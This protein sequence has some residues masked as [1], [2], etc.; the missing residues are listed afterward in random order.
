[1]IFTR[2][3]SFKRPLVLINAN[4]RISFSTLSLPESQTFVG[5]SELRK[6]V[7]ISVFIADPLIV[8]LEHMKEN[9]DFRNCVHY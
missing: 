6:L 5:F 7:V 4:V 2:T 8:L 9:S 1:M 3:L